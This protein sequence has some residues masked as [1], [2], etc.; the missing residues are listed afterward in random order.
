MLKQIGLHYFEL[1]LYSVIL[2]TNLRNMYRTPLHGIS[3]HC[4]VSALH[5]F[6]T[7][8]LLRFVAVSLVFDYSLTSLF[9]RSDS[10]CFE[11]SQL[12]GATTWKNIGCTDKLVVWWRNRTIQL[13]FT[14]SFSEKP[15]KRKLI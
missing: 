2:Q 5:E 11:C 8:E 1:K 14:R 3:I 6:I 15:H 7:G 10:C 4:G 12:L 9:A 13:M